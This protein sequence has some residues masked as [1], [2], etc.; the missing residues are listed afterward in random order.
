MSALTAENETIKGP[1]AGDAR[2]EE[3]T[4]LD[5][6]KIWKGGMVAVDATPEVQMA[7]DTAGLVVVGIAPASVDNTDDGE[8]LDPP[9]RGIFRMNNSETDPVAKEHIGKKCYV[10]DDNTVASDST[11]YVAAG[12]VVDVDDDGV[13]VDFRG[14]ALAVAQSDYLGSLAAD[15]ATPSEGQTWYNST[16]KAMK[17]RDDSATRVIT[18]VL[19]MMAFV[20]SAL[21]MPRAEAADVTP[22][23]LID[24]TTGQTGSVQAADNFKLAGTL[25][26]TGASTFTGGIA[27]GGS[28]TTIDI[29]GGT[30]DGAVIGG[31]AAGAI[32]GTTITG[33]T[34]TDGTISTT[35]GVLTGTLDISGATVTYRAIAAADLASGLQDAI[36]QVAITGTDNTDGTG[37]VTIQVQ[38]AAG[39]ALAGRF[40]IRTWRSAAA[41]GAAAAITSYAV[42]TGT[43]LEEVVANADRI[44]VTDAAGKVV[45]ALED[46]GTHHVQAHV[47]G[48][49]LGYYELT[50]TGP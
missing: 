31:A 2:V 22:I 16:E 13:W 4:I 5:A 46:G 29:N 10:E 39:N 1:L 15:P 24:A 36:P 34:I 12:V 44:V 47:G 49:A 40:L 14:P 50:I 33:A 21:L 6:E 3:L 27:D 7:S 43:Q 23:K 11:N 17:F 42:T 26:V 45:M 48:S 20:L 41:Y 37:S 32:T 18:F 8:T 30:I 25:E 38:D 35:A 19:A 9:L 28:V